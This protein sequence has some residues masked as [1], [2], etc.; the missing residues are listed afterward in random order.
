LT[1]KDLKKRVS[2]EVTQQQSK[3]IEKLQDKPFWIWDKQQHKQEDIRTDGDCCFNHIIG[4]PQKA[5]W[6]TSQQTEDGREKIQALSL[7]KDCYSMKLDLL[8]NAAVVD[9]AIRF[10][11]SKTKE[12]LKSSTE[13]DKEESNEPDYDE[14]EDQLE[15]EREEK[16][17]E[18]TTNQVF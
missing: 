3:L 8:T 1:F 11:S 13:G 14:D 17:G 5:A 12:N 16:T 10:V 18:I 7:A 2:L 6:N 9:D 4:L 15:E